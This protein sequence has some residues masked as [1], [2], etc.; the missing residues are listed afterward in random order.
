MRPKLEN[1]V[2]SDDDDEPVKT[3]SKEEI[4]QSNE[5]K[6]VSA[7][8][9]IRARESMR[10]KLEN[11]VFSDEIAPTP[12]PRRPSLL[13]GGVN[14]GSETI[15]VFENPMARN[16]KPFSNTTNK[17][18]SN[19]SNDDVDKTFNHIKEYFESF[20]ELS[21]LEV[22]NMIIKFNKVYDIYATRFSQMPVTD[23]L[24]WVVNI[25]LRPAF[26]DDDLM[27]RINNTMLVSA[28]LVS[29]SGSN[30]ISPPFQ[31]MHED[32]YRG[33]SYILFIATIFF[34]SSIF[35]GVFFVDNM[36]RAYNNKDRL[37]FIHLYHSI[38]FA[39]TYSLTHRLITITENYNIFNSAQHCMFIGTI[40]LIFSLIL[41]SSFNFVNDDTYVFTFA[42]ICCVVGLAYIGV[43]LHI[44]TAG[45]QTEHNK[46]FRDYIISSNG[47]VR[48]ELLSKCRNIIESN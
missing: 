17:N 16:V 15:E 7:P 9:I 25:V 24:D 28:L 34:L 19:S 4:I 30:F 18:T 8:K 3:T 22:A 41:S 1:N 48:E 26:F 12:P 6:E 39:L 47:Y 13:N 38:L 29:I 43:T 14:N 32:N 27:S 20:D 44:S 33:Y 31:D 37:D 2:F 35:L 21:T 46:F 5:I 10:P 23:R 42:V 36:S 11:N 45:K 40:F